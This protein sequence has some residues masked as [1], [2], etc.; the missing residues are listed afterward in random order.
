MFSYVSETGSAS[1][2]SS[3][4]ASRGRCSELL[5]YAAY[6]LLLVLWFP[7]ADADEVLSRIGT[8]AIPSASASSPFLAFDIGFAD[9]AID[10]YLLTNVSNK[11]LDVFQASTGAFLFSVA[12]FAGDHPPGWSRNGPSGVVT[13]AGLD[14][15][16]AWVGDGDST[17][18]VVALGAG[19]VID[20]IPTGGKARVDEVCYDSRDHVLLVENA[21]ES[22]PFVTFISTARGHAVLAKLS[23]PSATDGLEQPVWSPDTGLV[24]LAIPEVDHAYGAVALIDPVARKMLKTIRLERC[25]PNGA[26]LGSDEHLLLGC[27]EQA[28]KRSGQEL[29]SALMLDMR[30]GKK[31]AAFPEIVASDEIVFNHGD[32]RFYV[33]AY[34]NPSGPVLAAIDT[35]VPGRPLLLARTGVLAHSVA[36]DERTNHVF[37]PLRP[38][39]GDKSCLYGCVGVFA[40]S[41]SR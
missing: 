40:V 13:V 30:T 34:G 39:A 5:V 19:R 6:T 14:G 38:D 27:R 31:V 17:V 16:E 37:V 9:P 35:V 26:A 41:E 33:S 15:M 28:D 8:I 21:D 32:K 7:A 23:F 2:P 11:S 3:L 25:H 1:D 12:G 10:R 29:S 4:Q 22:T 24:Y 18:K 36:V 20:T